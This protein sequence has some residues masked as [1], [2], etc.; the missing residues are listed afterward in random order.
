[1]D[2]N[3]GTKD[4][5]AQRHLIDVA[6][7][8]A[9]AD[10]V[11]KRAKVVDVFTREIVEGDVAVAGGVVAGVGSYEGREEIDAAGRYLSPG[12]I[13]GH[14]HL[15]ST[16][17]RPSQFATAAVPHGTTAVIADPHEVANVCGTDGIDFIL[18][19]TEGIPMDVFIMI[20]SCVP[21][22]EYETSGSRLAASDIAP[23]MDNPRVRGLGEM[24]A[25]PQ[26]I[27][28][29]DGVLDKIDVPRREIGQLVDGHSPLVMGRD[30]NAYI[31]AGVGTDHE[32]GTVDEMRARLS[33]GMYVQLREGAATRDLD[34]LIPG[35]TPGNA[36]RCLFCTDD[37]HPEDIRARGHIDHNVRKAV[38]LGLDPLIASQLASINAASCYGLAGMGAIAPRYQADFILF[39]DIRE[40]RVQEVYKR[41]KLVAKDGRA[42]FAANDFADAKVTGTMHMK[43]VKPE[44][45]RIPLAGTRA[46][47]IGLKTY[48][49]VTEDLVMDVPVSGGCF[50]HDAS[51]DILKLAVVERHFA[52]G[53]IGLG[54]IS[55]FGLKGGAIASTITHDSHNLI[56]VGDNDPDMAAAAN[57]LARVGGGVTI[58]SGGRALSTLPLP[59]AGLMS[60]HSVNEVAEVVGQM[61]ARAKGLGVP[62]DVEPFMTLAFMALPVIPYLKLTD[63]GL[64]DVSRFAFTPIDA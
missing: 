48:S 45:F 61:K 1:M 40:M 6:A 10:L 12:L 33:L 25:Y 2:G 21:A 58:A 31:A 13:D 30:L 9:P 54:L 17:V 47:V 29:E 32:C 56:V 34:T 16:M 7:G 27:A 14:M 41:G 39:E 8:R 42:L 50:Q 59:I 23:Y 5:V 15:E 43:P 26:V 11:V 49:V 24:M 37:K 64:F 52:S 3:G 55:G 38:R 18:R 44:D 4:R 63:R 22:T 51:R 35:V 20:P 28:A 57:E 46:H 19:D 36:A 60:D 53:N 62:D